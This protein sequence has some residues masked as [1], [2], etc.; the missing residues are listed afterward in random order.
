MRCIAITLP[1]FVENEAE[2]ITRMLRSGVIDRVHIRK[3]SST[4][5]H[6][7]RLIEAMPAD[8][9]PRLS[10]HDHHTLASI[11]GCGVHLNARNPDITPGFHGTVSR[12]CHTPEE[13]RDTDDYHFLSP[14]FD[15]ISKPG[16]HPAF[17]PDQLRGIVDDSFVALG[18]VTP[19]K[20][21]LLKEIGF[22]GAAFLGYIWHGDLEENLSDIKHFTQQCFN[23]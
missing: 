6:M 5:R 4:L 22:G 11:Y 12:S 8:L 15:S 18:G 20:L 17:T 16:Y 21:P 2:A 1:D 23:S 10:L 3:P 7:Q 13:A 9:R 19:D 14:I